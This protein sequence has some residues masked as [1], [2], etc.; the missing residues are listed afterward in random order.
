MLS[1]LVALIFICTTFPV[2]F[3]AGLFWGFG[4]FLLE[5]VSKTWW[6]FKSDLDAENT[7]A[8]IVIVPFYAAWSGLTAFWS[9]PSAFWDWARYDH[10]WLAFFISLALLSWYGKKTA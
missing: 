3:F 9:L 4:M 10:P 5:I 2:W 8:A 7:L 1:F 6:V